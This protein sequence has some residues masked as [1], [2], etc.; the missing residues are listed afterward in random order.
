MTKKQKTMLVRIIIAFL[1][2]AVLLVCEKIFGIEPLEEFPVGF[3]VYCVP[4]LS[5]IHI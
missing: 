2:F 3:L 1:L 5:L 4:Y